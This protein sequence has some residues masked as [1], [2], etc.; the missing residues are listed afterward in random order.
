VVAV[1]R[2]RLPGKVD[3]IAAKVIENVSLR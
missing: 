2:F 3:E 1:P